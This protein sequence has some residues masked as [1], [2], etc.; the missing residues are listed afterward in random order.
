MRPPWRRRRSCTLGPAA[1]LQ[2]KLWRIHSAFDLQSE[3]FGFFEL[4]DQQ[5]GET[6]DRIPVVKGEI[7]IADRAYLQAPPTSRF[8]YLPSGG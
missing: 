6:L 4:T 1:K 5:G 3:R 2:N 7:R 8:P